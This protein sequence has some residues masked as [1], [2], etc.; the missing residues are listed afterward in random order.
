MAFVF[1]AGSPGRNFLLVHFTPL[2]AP[3]PA[4]CCAEKAT[5]GQSQS[6]SPN[7][8]THTCTVYSTTTDANVLYTHTQSQSHSNKH[9]HTQSQS[10]SPNTHTQTHTPGSD[11]SEDRVCPDGLPCG[12]KPSERER[13]CVLRPEQHGY[14]S[15]HQYPSG[16]G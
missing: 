5:L 8:H 13:T 4:A 9:T 7:T 14:P 6:H 1:M 2:T 16:Y 11:I 12:D 10:H 15:S 3:L